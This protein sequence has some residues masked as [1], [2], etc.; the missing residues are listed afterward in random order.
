MTIISTATN[1]NA[2]TNTNQSCALFSLLAGI[3][4]TNKLLLYKIQN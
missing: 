2:D 3:T 1:T 4:I